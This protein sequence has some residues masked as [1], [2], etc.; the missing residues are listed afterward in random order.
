MYRMSFSLNEG[1]C[2]IPGQ[3][4]GHVQGQEENAAGNTLAAGVDHMTADPEVAAEA[5]QGVGL[6]LIDPLD[7]I[8]DLDRQRRMLRK[9]MLNESFTQTLWI[10]GPVPVQQ[11]QQIT[12]DSWQFIER[13]LS[14]L[15]DLYLMM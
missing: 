3:D 14:C 9:R 5:D 4:P 10:K 7:H 12:S 1:V 11:L 2:L 15:L 6:G 13:L 8:Q